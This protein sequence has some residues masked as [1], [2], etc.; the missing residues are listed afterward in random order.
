MHL[1]IA[2]VKSLVYFVL[3]NL[4]SWATLGDTYNKIGRFMFALSSL[5]QWRW[6]E[7]KLESLMEQYKFLDLVYRVREDYF[8]CWSDMKDLARPYSQNCFITYSYWDRT[9]AFRTPV[10]NNSPIG[11][12]FRTL[13]CSSP[14]ISIVL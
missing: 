8:I 9:A 3:G 7:W 13:L 1:L 6:K 12:V 2:C 11:A 5:L 10:C 14:R 4:C